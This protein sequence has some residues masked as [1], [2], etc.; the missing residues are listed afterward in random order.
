VAVGASPS[1]ATLE[2]KGFDGGLNLRD[3]WAEIE[4]NETPLAWNVIYDERGAVIARLGLNKLNGASLLPQPPGYL[5]YSKVADALLAYISSDAGNGKLYKSTD[6]GATW[7]S[8]YAAFT[9]G[10]SGA[11]VDFHNAVVVVNT[12]DG[13]YVFPSGLGAPTHTAGGANNMDEIRGSTI[14]AWGNRV[15]VSGDIRNDATHSVARVAACAIADPTTWNNTVAGSWTNDLREVDDQSV[16]LIGAGQGVD[17]NQ[18]PTLYVCKQNSAYRINDTESGAYT[19]LHAS[20][21]GAASGNAAA[22]V[23]GRI[24]TINDVG[25]WVTDGIQTPKRI[26]DKIQPLFEQDLDLSTLATWT[27]GVQRDR[28]V[29]NATR[30]SGDRLQIEYHPLVGWLAVHKGLSL[31]PTTV[32]TKNT[33]KLIA[34]S[35]VNGKVYQQGVGGTDDGTAI[36]CFWSS[37]DFPLI[38]GREA[39]LRYLRMWGRGEFTMYMRTDYSRDQ[40]TA[41]PVSYSSGGFQWGIDRWNIGTWGRYVYVGDEL[42]PLSDVGRTAQIAIA[43]TTTTSAQA[44]QLLDDGV[45]PEVGSFG[46]YEAQLQL[47][48]CG[49]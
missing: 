14:A 11:I 28:V 49:R 41:F 32:Y 13:V 6:G 4:P 29:F 42:I 15:I 45:N 20:G 23:L 7:A 16:T 18:K 10:A 21:A 12:L 25:I 43:A 22:T 17:I 2:L 47:V 38:G 1:I 19:T 9:A 48:P 40:G 5:Y 39:R 44:P 27:A 34:A 35:S 26:S 30:K 33:R 46:F 24:V 8:V 36:D 37:K 31:G 3:A